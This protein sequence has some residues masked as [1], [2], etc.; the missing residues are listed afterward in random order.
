[1]TVRRSVKGRPLG[2]GREDGKGEGERERG[3]KGEEAEGGESHGLGR[4]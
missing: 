2:E 4:E 3:W 1:M